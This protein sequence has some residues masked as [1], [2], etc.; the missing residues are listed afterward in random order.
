MALRQPRYIHY[1]TP[2]QSSRSRGFTVYFFPV[3]DRPD[4]VGYQVTYCN[5]LDS[6]SRSVARAMVKE[7]DINY[8][9]VIDFPEHL[10]R[11]ESTAEGTRFP[12]DRKHIQWMSNCWAWALKYFL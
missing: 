7:K 8:I 12:S 5:K 2:Y 1:Q 6:F 11:I 3:D 9:R 10:A 4:L